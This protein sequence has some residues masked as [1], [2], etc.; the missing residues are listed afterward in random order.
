MQRA[1]KTANWAD[2]Q[3]NPLAQFCGER[4]ALSILLDPQNEVVKSRPRGRVTRHCLPTRGA[5]LPQVVLW[6]G[7]PRGAG[8]IVAGLV[9]L[10]P[11]TVNATFAYQGDALLSHNFSAYG[12]DTWR[13]TPRLT[14]THGLR[15]DVNP[16]LKG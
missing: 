4:E 1:A 14:L 3:G 6:S 11:V 7:V 12:Q 10:K 16:P 13:V 5:T 9:K 2:T 15:W 8:A